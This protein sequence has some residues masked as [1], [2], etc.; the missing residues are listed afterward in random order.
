MKSMKLTN[1]GRSNVSKRP[2]NKGHGEIPA[3]ER[4]VSSRAPV[5]ALAEACRP[6]G[7]QIQQKANGSNEIER[8]LEVK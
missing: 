7:S 4:K 5:K 1:S 2:K 6:K 3:R 8:A